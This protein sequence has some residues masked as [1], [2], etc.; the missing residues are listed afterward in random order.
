[1]INQSRFFHFSLLVPNNSPKYSQRIWLKIIRCFSIA[2]AS[3]RK[4][5]AF[6]AATFG[7]FY[8]SF[9]LI[10]LKCCTN[11]SLFIFAENSAEMQIVSTLLG[12]MADALRWL[13]AKC[14]QT[15]L[16]IS[17]EISAHNWLCCHCLHS[18]SIHNSN[19]EQI[20]YISVWI[21]SFLKTAVD[22]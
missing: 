10:F 12:G 11:L 18:A 20:K 2:I 4:F 3:W 8:K 13:T 14:W 19:V 6:F 16:P 21:Y 1:M 7:N 15:F 9:N 5:S 22:F 17:W